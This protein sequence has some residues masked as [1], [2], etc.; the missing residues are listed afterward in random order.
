MLKVISTVGTGFFMNCDDAFVVLPG[1]FYV[2]FFNKR[3]RSSAGSFSMLLRKRYTWSFQRLEISGSF[4]CLPCFGHKRPQNPANQETQKNDRKNP[5]NARKNLANARKNTQE[6][7][8]KIKRLKRSKN[9]NAYYFFGVGSSR[10]GIFC[11]I[12]IHVCCIFLHECY[13]CITVACNPFWSKAMMGFSLG[14]FTEWAT[15]V[16]VAKQVVPCPS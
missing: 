6:T 16:D 9:Q 3:P 7:A 4:G 10:Y 15:D 13:V 1:C 8:K 12:R 11:Y 2:L 14:L 5:Q